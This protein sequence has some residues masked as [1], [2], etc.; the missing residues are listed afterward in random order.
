[1]RKLIIWELPLPTFQFSQDFAVFVRLHI[2]KIVL[3]F[4]LVM[5]VAATITSYHYGLI[6]AYGDAESHINIA[7][8]VVSGLT[9]GMAQLGG[10]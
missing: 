3:L 10:I 2:H 7:K 9:P 4:A 1:M 6:L 8:K 5:T